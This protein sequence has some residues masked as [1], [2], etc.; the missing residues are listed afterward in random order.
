MSGKYRTICADPRRRL[1]PMNRNQEPEEKVRANPKTIWCEEGDHSG[2]KGWGETIFQV[3]RQRVDCEC[4]CHT[5]QNFD[6]RTGGS[7]EDSNEA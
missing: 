5:P 7:D 1:A 2:C 6:S 4:A 3:P